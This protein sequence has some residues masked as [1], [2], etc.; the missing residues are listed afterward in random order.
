L[1]SIGVA[2]VP[3]IRT[4]PLDLDFVPLF[5]ADAKTGR[6]CSP[7]YVSVLSGTKCKT[8]LLPFNKPSKGTNKDTPV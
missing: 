7:R 1:G 2:V 4:V 3:S 6:L 8:S 5:M